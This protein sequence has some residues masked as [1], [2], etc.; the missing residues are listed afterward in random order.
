[1]RDLLSCYVYSSVFIWE[2]SCSCN[3]RACL[4]VCASIHTFMRWALSAVSSV[5]LACCFTDSNTLRWHST[6]HQSR[7]SVL[8]SDP[9]C[10]SETRANKSSQSRSMTSDLASLWSYSTNMNPLIL[11]SALK[12]SR[13]EDHILIWHFK[14]NTPH[15][16]AR[17]CKHFTHICF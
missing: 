2:V 9:V 11:T 4:C 17:R 14:W 3:V 1:M 5:S 12:Y 15:L 16:R 10:F 13:E 6:T 8:R 7:G